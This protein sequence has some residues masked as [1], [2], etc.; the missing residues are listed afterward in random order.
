MKLN[1]IVFLLIFKS[2]SGQPADFPWLADRHTQNLETVDTIPLPGNFE[3][4]SAPDSGFARWLRTLPLKPPNSL[5]FLYDGSKK[6][7]QSAHFRVLDIDV[8]KR[9]LQQCADA[10]IR[11][12]AEYLYHTGLENKIQFNFTDGSAARYSDWKSGLRPIQVSDKIQWKQKTPQPPGYADF[13]NYL[14]TIFIYAGSYSLSREMEKIGNSGS[15]RPGDVFLQ[16]GFPGH[17]VIVMDMAVQRGSGE[18]IMLLAQSYMP[19]QDI[20][21]LN[22]PADP[23]LSPWYEIQEIGELRTPEWTFSFDELYRFKNE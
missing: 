14:T 4:T 21:I 11:L 10:V 3:R 16:G 8:G 23:G 17:A 22:N 12:Y 2:L 20:H 7:N 19:A 13:R 15:I 9:D 1:Y 5:V 6:T 18:K